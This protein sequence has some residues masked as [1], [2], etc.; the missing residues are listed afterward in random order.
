MKKKGF[1]TEYIVLALVIVVLSAYLL[2]RNSN[3]IQYDIPELKPVTQE[4]ISKIEI[5]RPKGTVVLK[6]NEKQWV[7]DKEGYPLDE[8]LMKDILKSLANFELTAMVSQSKNY[9]TYGL[10]D[11]HR[12]TVKAYNGDEL[13]REF[14]MGKPASTFRHTYV[15]LADDDRVFHAKESFRNFYER[16]LDE[17]RDKTVLRFDQ[18]EIS[19]IIVNWKNDSLTFTKKVEQPEVK[20]DAKEQ[21]PKAEVSWV[22][23]EG[24]IA[25]Q[26][27]MDTILRNGSFLK[28]AKYE[29]EKKKEDLG[30][31]IYTITF[32]GSKDYTVSLYSQKEDK[33]YP[34]VSSGSPYLC[35]LSSYSVDNLMKKIGDFFEADKKELK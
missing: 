25:K 29:Y 35:L 33:N 11:D 27:I 17:M 22:S 9:A 15:R 10:T 6:K 8:M 5:V 1:K 28:C 16:E 12:I 34:A 4:E 24:K 14:Q 20:P 23:Q 31:P 7:S 13:V 2:M 3:R 21:Q 19:Q 18:N 32:K 30:D 26:D